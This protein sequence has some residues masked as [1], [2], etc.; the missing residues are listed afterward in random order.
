MQ[1]QNDYTFKRYEDEVSLARIDRENPDAAILVVRVGN[2]AQVFVRSELCA[3]DG[4]TDGYF[5]L[6]TDDAGHG[7]YRVRTRLNPGFWTRREA[8]AIVQAYGVWLRAQRQ[9]QRRQVT[10]VQAY[11][12]EEE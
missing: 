3:R 5:P 9:G 10:R 6:V 4:F 11:R 8:K 2:R 12:L 1:N 7:L